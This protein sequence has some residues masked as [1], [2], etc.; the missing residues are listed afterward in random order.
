VSTEAPGRHK[1]NQA[2]RAPRLVS[3][4]IPTGC[5][6]TAHPKPGIPQQEN[7]ECSIPQWNSKVRSR[8]RRWQPTISSI[9]C[10]LPWMA[11]W[12]RNRRAG[13]RLVNRP[14]FFG[15][16][17]PP[18]VELQAFLS[19]TLALIVLA[20]GAADAWAACTVAAP[21]DAEEE[22]AEADDAG[23]AAGVV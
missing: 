16:R 2:S 5:G 7:Y 1:A 23:L 6:L 10:D 11:A 8:E 18:R 14:S 4:Q 9:V 15:W 22:P 20:C 21:E 13:G 12:F 17:P 19:T 3:I